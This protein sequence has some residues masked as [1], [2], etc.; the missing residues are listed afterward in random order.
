MANYRGLPEHGQLANNAYAYDK[1]LR[2][3]ALK[4]RTPEQEAK[5]RE[6]EAKFGRK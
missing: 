3:R 6:L 5:L 1:W 2:L 4:S